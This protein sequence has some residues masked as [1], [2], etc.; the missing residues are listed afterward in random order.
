V[1]TSKLVLLGLVFP[2]PKQEIGWKNVSEMTILY[3]VGRKT[4]LSH[5]AERLHLVNFGCRR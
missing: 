4:L 1:H 5:C 2:V 3:L